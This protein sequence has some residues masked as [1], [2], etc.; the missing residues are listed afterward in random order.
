MN[1]IMSTDE[2]TAET[3]KAIIRLLVTRLAI[4]CL[5]VLISGI[6]GFARMK[7]AIHKR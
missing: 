4:G 7:E 3:T 5:P 1:E 2:T 6:D